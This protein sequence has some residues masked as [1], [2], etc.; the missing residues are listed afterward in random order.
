MTGINLFPEAALKNLPLYLFQRSFKFLAKNKPLSIRILKYL[1]GIC[2]LSISHSL[3]LCPFGTMAI[4][5]V[6]WCLAA[7]F[8]ADPAVGTWLCYCYKH[9]PSPGRATEQQLWCGA[10]HHNFKNKTAGTCSYTP[11]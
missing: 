9:D 6:S 3:L 5:Q 4:S 8:L 1:F 10:S 2:G 11:F 7:T